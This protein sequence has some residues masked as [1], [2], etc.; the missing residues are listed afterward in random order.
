M[1]FTKSIIFIFVII[2]SNVVFAS[3]NA[4][5]NKLNF[6]KITKPAENNYE[7]E[8]FETTNNLLRKAGEESL[9]CGEKIIV[10]GRLVDENC[11]PIADAKIYI[12]QVDCKGKYPYKPLKDHIDDKL[13][14]VKNLTT[15]TGN[16][17]A[18]TNNKG[19]FHF[20]TIYPK[21]V[22]NLASHI[23]I[24]VEHR[25]LG[26]LQT[27]LMLKNHKVSDPQNYPELDGIYEI[28]GKKNI[29]IYNYQVVM[30]GSTEDSY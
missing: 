6:C 1:E 27:R 3:G 13:V 7:P 22:E 23:N 19:E 29:S 5:L 16:G 9:Y 4:H 18:T 25:K 14:N 28:A 30:Q 15:F 11:T 17:T 26:M 8:V 2:F 21:A 12:W 20:I 24:R 10:A